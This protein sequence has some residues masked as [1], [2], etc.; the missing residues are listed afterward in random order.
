MD[1][2]P[3]YRMWKDRLDN[4]QALENARSARRAVREQARAEW[5]ATWLSYK[6][7]RTLATLALP[8]PRWWN[9]VGWVRWLLRL[10][11]AGRPG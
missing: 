8:L 1:D 10:H 3:Q 5:Q 4:E 11:A 9:L 7:R 6:A 2:H